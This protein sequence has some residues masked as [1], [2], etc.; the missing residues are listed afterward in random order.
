MEV[1][2]ADK[3]QATGLDVAHNKI[4]IQ[5]RFTNAFQYPE[6]L[7]SEESEH[8][9]YKLWCYIF[10]LATFYISTK[11]KTLCVE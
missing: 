2:L 5:F 11:E 6:T 3:N 8:K 7:L 10:K 4:F 1:D 9:D